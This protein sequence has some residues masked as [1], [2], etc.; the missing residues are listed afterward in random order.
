[1]IL[2]MFRIKPV[3]NKCFNDVNIKK[4]WNLFPHK[5]TQYI[6]ISQKGNSEVQLKLEYNEKE[7][8]HWMA[9][10]IW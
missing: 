8:I 1:M 4:E 7:R 3:I 10:T 5:T 2:L 9:C 6:S